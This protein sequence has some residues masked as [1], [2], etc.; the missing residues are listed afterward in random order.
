M[1]T[2]TPSPHHHHNTTTTQT[3]L[4]MER[5][6]PLAVPSK[7]STTV[8]T[9]STLPTRTVQSGLESA[10][11]DFA[12][13]IKL[14]FLEWQGVCQWVWQL[15]AWGVANMPDMPTELTVKFSANSNLIWLSYG[16]FREKRHGSWWL[17]VSPTCPVRQVCLLNS[18]L[19]FQLILT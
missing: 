14:I 12:G 16:T 19:T 4:L 17:G 13:N 18:Q 5:A 10:T 11:T 1:F 9:H 3:L 15:L 2:F 7:N 8:V 6:R